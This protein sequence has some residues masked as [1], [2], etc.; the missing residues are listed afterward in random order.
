MP[1]P[2]S[3][4]RSAM[5]VTDG[6][7]TT[8]WPSVAPRAGDD[9]SWVLAMLAAKRRLRGAPVPPQAA[10]LSPPPRVAAAMPGRDE[11]T[12]AAIEPR[13]NHE[14][15]RH[16]HPSPTVVRPMVGATELRLTHRNSDSPHSG[17]RAPTGR[18]RVARSYVSPQPLKLIRLALADQF[19]ITAVILD[20]PPLIDAMERAIARHDG[21]IAATR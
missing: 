1:L 2:R 15:C 6:R 11:G 4:R 10:D 9:K 20:P 19:W 14:P 5:A 18:R 8:S 3:S 7:A 16:D 21:L 12:G 13:N 17:G